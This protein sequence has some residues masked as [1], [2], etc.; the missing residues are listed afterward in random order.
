MKSLK[1]YA[2]QDEIFKLVNTMVMTSSV[3]CRWIVKQWVREG[4]IRTVLKRNMLMHA[5]YVFFDMKHT[6]IKTSKNVKNQ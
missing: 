3:Y 5:I 2:N 6:N 1:V 4:I